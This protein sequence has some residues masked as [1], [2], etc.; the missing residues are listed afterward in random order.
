[1]KKTYL[2]TVLFLLVSAFGFSQTA[3]E[4]IQKNLEVTG[5]VENWKK[6]NST[7]IKGEIILGEDKIPVEL[8]QKKPNL[9]K[10]VLTLNGKKQTTEVYDGTKA[11]EFDFNKNKLVENKNYVPEPF[12]SDLLEY[13]EKGFV[14]KYLGKEKVGEVL[15]FKVSLSKKGKII[16]YYF[17]VSTYNLIKEINSRETIYYSNFRKVSEYTMPFQVESINKED[18]TKFTLEID[19]IEVNK[20]YSSNF[21]TKD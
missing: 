18:N 12:D 14:A 17:D 7:Y 3:K 11:Y 2:Y 13:S 10:T 1:M 8:F 4:I 19:T 16:L 6:L 20:K 9:T 15:C 5:T 21:F